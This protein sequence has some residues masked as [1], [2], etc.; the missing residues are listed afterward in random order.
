[1]ARKNRFG[2]FESVR[3][4]RLRELKIDSR[5]RNVVE[6]R[7]MS[8]DLKHMKSLRER[9]SNVVINETACIELTLSPKRLKADLFSFILKR[10]IHTVK[11][12]I[13]R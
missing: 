13:K 12:F 6:T 7:G 11:T 10:N 9:T 2:P 1:M 3:V 4:L 5:P 8:L